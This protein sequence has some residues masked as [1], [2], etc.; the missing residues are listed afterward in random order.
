MNEIKITVIATEE[1]AEMK[2]KAGTPMIVIRSVSCLDAHSKSFQ[3]SVV[4]F[5][6]YVSLAERIATGDKFTVI[7]SIDL[8]TYK[9]KRGTWEKSLSVYATNIIHENEAAYSD[10]KQS[11]VYENYSP[12]LL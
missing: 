2:T 12:H 3:I 5:N 4:L 6:E 1:P 9:S 8:R 7:G 10:E 11:G